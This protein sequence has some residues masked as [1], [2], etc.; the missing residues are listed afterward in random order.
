M[1]NP[2]SPKKITDMRSGGMAKPDRTSWAQPNPATIPLWA[3]RYVTYFWTD[4][5]YPQI[6]WSLVYRW[7]LIPLS[8]L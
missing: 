7:S 2:M 5:V 1:A 8:S 4:S 3:R 6:S